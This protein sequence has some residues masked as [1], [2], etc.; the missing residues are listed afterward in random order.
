[1]RVAIIGFGGIGRGYAGYLTAHGHEPVIWS[2]SGAALADFEGDATLTTTGK[3]EAA[4]PL[5]IARD[6]AEAV[7][8]A[9]AVIVAVQANGFKAVLDALA[10]HLAAGQLV[11]ISAHCSFAAL[12]LHRLLKERGL[13]I[14][15]ASWATTALTARKSGPRSVHI[16]GI[17]GQLDV[18]TLPV[19]HAQAGLAVCQTLFGD[20][21]KASED[22]LAIM[23]SNLN[24]PAHVA[25]MLGN[26]T[27]AERGEDWPNYGSITQGV[28]RIV[29]A[30]D[31]ERLA[32]A[33]AFGLSVRS[34]QDHYVH[35]FGV[36]PGPVGEMAAAVYRNRP[37]L[38]GPK[39]LDT[40]FIT[41]DVPFGL[42]PLEALGRVAGVPLPLHQAGIALFDA[43]CAQDFRAGND[44]LP[45]LGLER[46]T[47]SELHGQLRGA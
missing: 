45:A 33:R 10:P 30:M 42:V 25:N 29:D 38:M 20:R 43:I 9:E 44:L 4:V 19:R 27:R 37:E 24:P 15:I 36:S 28:G 26:L 6:C 16:S 3:L 2:P 39:T 40:R 18:A 32:L 23:L 22:V 21:F 35:S 17:R 41:E 12:Y 34:V 5:R 13:D 14:P 31:V 47:A 8:G 7:A 1:M 11:I 46:L